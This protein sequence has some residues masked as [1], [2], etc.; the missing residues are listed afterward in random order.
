[1]VQEIDVREP[2]DLVQ[3]D[4]SAALREAATS[5]SDNLLAGEH[6]VR[7]ASFDATTGNAAVVVSDSASAVS[8]DYP[9]RALQHLQRISPAL[10]LDPAQAPEYVADASSHVTSA[11][12][13]AVHL[14]QLYK[15]IPIYDAAET[16]RFDT[17]GRLLEVAG[18]SVTVPVD[19]PVANAVSAQAAL[20]TAAAHVAEADDAAD[21]PLDPFGQPLVDPALDVTDFAPVERTSGAD[22]PDR[23]TTFDAPPFPHVVTV[24]LMWFPLA[25][26]L[27]LT[28]H[29]KLAVP[30]GAVYRVMVDA[31]TNEILLAKRLT[32]RLG[33]VADVVLS[34]GDA[35]QHITMP[36][37]ADSYGAPL[38]AQLPAG[39]PDDWLV[40][41]STRGATV[42]AVLEPGAIPVQGTT[43]GGS[44]TFT[45]QSAPDRY[46][47]N[48]FALC[49][50][51]HDLLYLLGFREAEGN[52]QTDNHSRG[53]RGQDPVVAHVYPAA[54]WGTANMGTPADGSQ[55]TMNMGLVTSTGRHTALDPDVVFHEYTHGLTNRLVG[56]PLDDTSLD[57]LQS[58]GMGEGWSDFFACIALGKTVVGDWVV[59]SPKGIRGFPYD[60]NFPD[61]YASLGTGRY[62]GSS[63][64]NLGEI[65]CATLMTLSRRIGA[66][67]TAQIVVDGLKLTAANPSFLA[68]RD[69][70]VLAADRYAAARGDSAT[71]RSVYVDQVWGVFAEYGM[72]PAARTGGAGTLS[73]I[74]ADFTKPPPPTDDTP[75][76]SVSGTA[77]P[78]L[79]IPDND[80]HGVMSG[81][82]LPDVGPVRRI[83]VSVD[84][85]HTYRGDL[86]VRLVSPS[87]KP[88]ILHHRAGGS[89]DDLKQTWR[90]S[91][92]AALT[93]LV[94]VE[95]GGTWRLEISDLASRDTGILNEWSILVEVAEASLV[96]EGEAVPGLL[97]PDD[98]P[99]GVRS[100]LTLQS[101][102]AILSLSLDVDITH[103]YIGDLE[104]TL[105]GPDATKVMVH[106]RAGSGA[107]NLIGS[108]TSGAGGPLGPFVG[109]PAGGTWQ[110]QVADL[111]GQDVGKLNRWKISAKV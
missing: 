63:V 93:A 105:H 31:S 68:A 36:R 65:W 13:V 44:V 87:G 91:D 33:G 78:G 83:E 109:K 107:D 22:R 40:N 35:P 77:T 45:P 59:D 24:A 66:W 20:R 47:V 23:P 21:A 106:R 17:D 32:R 2:T 100:E 85:T 97:I 16:V 5:V 18:R 94:G 103:T 1:M 110:L 42:H 98:S 70:I 64:H 52:F 3:A 90:S 15:G 57:A 72:G 71:E 84:V 53:G 79:T 99:A 25:A 12:V 95:A 19:T 88:A 48:L 14:R 27:R 28:W 73:G 60:D 104:V 43:A 11:G 39:F 41:Q 10:G 38:G 74:K 37:P 55:P 7:I 75:M 101:D 6:R 82:D 58:G 49:S 69:A 62:A 96:A 111:A 56:G 30:G 46:V 102:D 34:A 86:D 4:R 29:T 54:V 67:E 50:S 9:A 26:D 76:T 51:M 89:A 80:P 61:N 81:I 92:L 8:G 108:Y